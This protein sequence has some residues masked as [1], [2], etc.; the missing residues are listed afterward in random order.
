[1]TKEMNGKTL[2]QLEDL[3][4]HLELRRRRID[5]GLAELKRERQQ[6]ADGCWASTRRR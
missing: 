6:V 4:R 5:H 2:G 3:V 1:M